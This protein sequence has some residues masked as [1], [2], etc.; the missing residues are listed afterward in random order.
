LYDV[1]PKANLAYQEAFR[2]KKAMPGDIR[3]DGQV[4]VHGYRKNR[5]A[6]LAGRVGILQHYMPTDGVLW[7]FGC[8]AGFMMAYY[9]SAGLEV[10]GT[11]VDPLA[12][13]ALAEMNLRVV[14]PDEVEEESVDA[15]F[16]FHVLEHLDDPLLALHRLVKK[17]KG[18]GI[19]VIEVPVDRFKYKNEFIGHRSEFSRESFPRFVLQFPLVPIVMREGIQT[20]AVI[21]IGR[22]AT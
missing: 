6:L 10:M 3:P 21:Y 20:P 5:L 16:L 7:D 15:L 14:Q 13:E 19:V 11:E 17:V 22:R 4:D 12:L 18:G 9:R 2:L 1:S 8:G